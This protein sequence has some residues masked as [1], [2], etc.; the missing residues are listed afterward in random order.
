MLRTFPEDNF[1]TTYYQTQFRSK[2][3]RINISRDAEN[4]FRRKFCPPIWY[5]ENFLHHFRRWS[6]SYNFFFSLVKI[7]WSWHGP[8]SWFLWRCCCLLL[9]LAVLSIVSTAVSS[10]SFSPLPMRPKNGILYSLPEISLG[11]FDFLN[12]ENGAF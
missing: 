10:N 5:L 4:F 2:K 12:H 8:K 1:T 9:L 3:F 6:I 11:F 7:K